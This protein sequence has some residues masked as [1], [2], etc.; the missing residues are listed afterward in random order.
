[1]TDYLVCG[2]VRPEIVARIVAGIA[3]GCATAGCA[4]IG[5]ETAEHPGHFGP[6][7]FDLAGA[8]TGVVEADRLLGPDR[9]APG[10]VVL[11]LASSGL[12]SNRFSLVRQI[13]EKA[14][15][16]LESQPAELSQPLC[17][18]LSAPTR[19]YSKDCLAV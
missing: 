10:D 14:G 5:G 3:A 11:A 12:H 19:I 8:A 16:D 18:E 15:L 9:V 4:L 17:A 6:D 13:L 1:M 2:K 7:E